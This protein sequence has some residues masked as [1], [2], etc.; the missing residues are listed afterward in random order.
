VAEAEAAKEAAEERIAAIDRRRE[1]AE[2][3][4]REVCCALNPNAILN[5]NA[6]PDSTPVTKSEARSPKPEARNHRFE[7]INPQQSAPYT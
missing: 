5:P 4:M 3:T 2:E 1:Q 6:S 7:T